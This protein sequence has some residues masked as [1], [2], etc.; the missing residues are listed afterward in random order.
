MFRK[1]FAQFH[2]KIWRL[3]TATFSDIKAAS[4]VMQ[5]GCQLACITS[6]HDSE[7]PFLSFLSKIMSKAV[8]FLCKGSS[9]LIFS[10]GSV[11]RQ[12]SCSMVS[13]GLTLWYRSYVG[14]SWLRLAKALSLKWRNRLSSLK[15]LHVMTSAIGGNHS[16]RSSTCHI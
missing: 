11:S 6:C 1:R 15:R 12:A 8:F 10:S 2:H 3:R 14:S 7:A 13:N 5:Q 4:V 16:Q 9:T